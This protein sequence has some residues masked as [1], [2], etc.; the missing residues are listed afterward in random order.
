MRCFAVSAANR[1]GG[2]PE[3]NATAAFLPRSRWYTPCLWNHP[4]TA[5]ETMTATM[6][7]NTNE[8]PP[9]PSTMIT[10]RLMLD[11]NTPPRVAAAPMSA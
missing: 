3:R 10:T 4:L 8:M 11:R 6:M 9:V 2:S 5:L 7:Q 1:L